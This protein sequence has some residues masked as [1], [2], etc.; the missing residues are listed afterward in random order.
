MGEKRVIEAT[1][2]DVVCDEQRGAVGDAHNPD[3][4]ALIGVERSAGDDV[5]EEVA[6]DAAA[7]EKH[8]GEHRLHRRRHLH[9]LDSSGG[10]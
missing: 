1:G 6:A 7:T 10:N 9:N 2:V 5:A 3:G 4:H 8:H